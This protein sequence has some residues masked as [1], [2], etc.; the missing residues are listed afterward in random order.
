M[1]GR[2][3][4]S[5]KSG[6]KLVVASHNEGKVREI[7]E[8]L[9][10]YGIIT[11]SAA[12]LDLPEP[13]ETGLTFA[14][15]ALI[16]A[17]SAASHSGL[18]ALAD[19]SGLEVEALGGEPGIYSARWGGEEKDFDL[20]MQKVH[21]ALEDKGANTPDQRRAN[22]MCALCL[23]YPDGEGG[24]SAYEVFEGKVY[25]NINWPMRGDNG[26]GYDAIFTPD[27]H[28]MTFAEM[29]PQKKHDMS[30]RAEAFKLFVEACFEHNKQI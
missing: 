19:D 17:Q 26:F 5:L 7:R 1:N 13:E 21:E 2:Q 16:K 15:N 14:E 6:D 23:A 30:H 3:Q 25:G 9:E 29:E 22:F 12:E 4:M 18:A 11:V 27:G 8:L 28:K 10:P 24:I 20:A